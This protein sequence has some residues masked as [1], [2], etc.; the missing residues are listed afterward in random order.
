MNKN[1]Y[2][3]AVDSVKF[4]ENFEQDTIERM[5]RTAEC[6]VEKEN[7]QMKTH[8][9]IRVPVLAAVLIALLAVTAF[10]MPSLL[11]L[12][13]VV[14]K[15]GDSV[16]AEAFESEDAIRIDQTVQTGD[17]T[18]TLQGIISGKGLTKYSQEAE[19]DKSYIVASVARTDG[20][21]LTQ[22]GEA[23][24]TFSP[25]VSG[26][27]PWQVNAW[28]L[29]GGYSSF[30]DEGI[31]YYIFDCENLEI[32]ADHT[33]YLAAFEGM[34]PSADIFTIDEKGAIAF[35]EGYDKPHAMFV[36]PLD[37]EKANSNAVSKLLDSMGIEIE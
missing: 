22:A 35:K 13:E 18:I 28:T 31:N 25:L 2:K 6:M 19:T 10:A 3:N 1:Q 16:L 21:D 17:Y 8:K 23:E 27:K 30:I 15:S 24:I 14:Q 29:G 33:V 36:L 7:D 32:F 9:M 4:S 34:G 12:K 20:T 37:S 26:Y 11:S 5:R